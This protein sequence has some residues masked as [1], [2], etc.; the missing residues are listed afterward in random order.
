VTVLAKQA[1]LPPVF[2]P[3]DA[4]IGKTGNSIRVRLEATSTYF[5]EQASSSK[6]IS[7][8]ILPVGTY[9]VDVYYRYMDVAGGFGPEQYSGS[10]DFAVEVN[11][12]Q[13]VSPC[14]PGVLSVVAGAFQTTSIYTPFTGP[15]DVLV[16]DGQLR[17][18]PNVI[19]QFE[20]LPR[21]EDYLLDTSQQ[22]QAALSFAQVT[23]DANGIARVTATA[24]GVAGTYQYVAKVI[25]K[26]YV[27]SAYIVMR[28]GAGDSTS[29]APFAPVVEFYNQ[30]RD[31]YFVTMDS[32]EMSLLDR[33]LL[34]G[35]QRTGGVFLGYRSSQVSSPVD[36]GPVCRFYGRPQAG[37]DSHFFSASPFECN[38]VEEKFSQSWILE[39]SDAFREFLPNFVTGDCGQGTVAL[40][41]AYNNR[42][43]A[44]H[45][46]STNQLIIA[47]MKS[48][49]WV[50]EGYGPSA[51]AM[52]VPQ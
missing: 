16:T 3:A 48:S 31:H 10:L 30:A 40:Y 52:C 17:P 27:P 44:N 26:D 18:V 36:A 11:G 35:W 38:A 41:R 46:Y 21:P 43:D 37:L 47:G 4:F 34:Q 24:N 14:A 29:G 2:L 32:T 15:I 7:L 5:P 51:V 50:A 8:G 12:A 23:T 25:G 33:G 9:H 20:R 1:P 22:P 19:V 28:N 39:T 42:A 6:A 45:R 13:G 49:G